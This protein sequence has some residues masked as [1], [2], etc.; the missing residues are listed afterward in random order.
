MILNGKKPL[1]DKRKKEHRENL[2]QIIRIID[3]TIFENSIKGG[4]ITSLKSDVIMV[5]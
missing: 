1:L 2:K 4:I 3:N 5:C